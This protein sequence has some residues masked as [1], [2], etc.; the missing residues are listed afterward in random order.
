VGWITLVGDANFSTLS[1]SRAEVTMRG[2]ATLATAHRLCGYETRASQRAADRFSHRL[3]R[4]H[5]FG[6][7][8]GP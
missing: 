6:K 2:V 3:K 7:A 5:Q 8:L 4:R 1:G